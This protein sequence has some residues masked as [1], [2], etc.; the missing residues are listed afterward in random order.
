MSSAAQRLD[1]DP[2]PGPV[3]VEARQDRL[4]TIAQL[5]DWLNISKRG[6][7]RLVADSQ[8]RC[9]KV[10]G[11]LRVFESSVILYIER[12]TDLYEI[13]N[14]LPVDDNR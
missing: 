14:G 8:F 4:L 9:C 6:A 10:G 5:A 11:A 1:G 2:A 12:I 3:R 7:Y 13:E